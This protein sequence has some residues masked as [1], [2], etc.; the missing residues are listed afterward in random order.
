VFAVCLAVVLAAMGWISLTALR[1]DRAEATARA[2][3][4]LEENVRLAL[5]RMDTAVA[6]IL[7]QESARPYF[8]YSTFLPVDRAYSEMFGRGPGGEVLLPS[9]LLQEPSPYILVY[10]QFQPDGS[11]ISPQ[12]PL[13][14]NYDLA[15]PGHVSAESVE[16]AQEHLARLDAMVDRRRLV[17]MLPSSEPS[18]VE[19]V[20]SPGG[21]SQ[22][23]RVAQREQRAQAQRKGKGAVEFYQRNE[24]VSQMT[25]SANTLFNQPQ[26]MMNQAQPAPVNVS[27]LGATDVRGVVMTPRWIDGQLV[28]ARR[29]AV[30][31]VEY[32]QGC[33]LDWQ[34]IRAW[35]LET[36]EDLLPR[37]ELDAIPETP[38][39][40]KA[41]VLAALPVRLKP[42]TLSVD[43]AAPL[44]PIVLALA[45][46]WACMLVSAVAVGVLLWGVMRLSR[47]RAA[48]VSAVTH[49]LRT[50]LT[51]FHMYT[52]M[53]AEGM[54]PDERQ[55][56]YLGTLRA[57]ASRLGHLVENVLSYARLERG[58]ADGR[59]EEV[60]A[61]QLLEAVESRLAERAAQAGMD[62]VVEGDERDFAATVRA[63]RSA[64]EQILFNLVDNA[65]KYADSASD[66]RIHLSASRTEGA[67]RLR[68]RDH[69]PGVSSSASRRLFHPFSKSAKEAAH[70]APGVGLGLALSR[71]LARD[72]GAR[73]HAD[74]TVRDGA[75]LVLTLSRVNRPATS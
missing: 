70:T 58:R 5:W 11:L 56:E 2:Q 65:C 63:N 53:L 30:G 46:A 34:E 45:I 71:R 28:L 54:V 29:V 62:L 1:L 19:L 32:V 10:F 31:G 51:T 69:G 49:E 16:R 52:E 40:E 39:E 15:V 50:P 73:L 42:G 13:G 38:V 35:L 74:S 47:R 57:E 33:L 72:M 18:P 43:S 4:V 59:V 66:R 55:H 44:S 20:F 48:F 21:P 24:A 68:V 26:N 27:Q 23:A 7:A 61:G 41:R 17:Q 9:P 64:V 12:V 25:Q 75:C 37:A 22:Q 3:A 14:A 8:A 6:P 36:V 67:V 60:S